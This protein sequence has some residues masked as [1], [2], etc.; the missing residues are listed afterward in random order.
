MPIVELADGPL[1]G[2][3][4][5]AAA[6]GA[7][8]GVGHPKLRR[9]LSAEDAE[10]GVRWVMGAA[11]QAEDVTPDAPLRST[12]PGDDSLIALAAEQNAALVSGDR[13]LLDLKE[14]I[15]VYAPRD[16]LELIELS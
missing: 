1:R 13:H 9:H 16:F 3:R 12:D 5:A 8:A 6:R 4:L 7:P 10:A 2:R 11:T 15:P 14:R